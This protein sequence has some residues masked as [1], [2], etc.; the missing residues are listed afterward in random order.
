MS[1]RTTASPITTTEVFSRTFMYHIILLGEIEELQKKWIQFV[2]P[3]GTW[4]VYIPCS[5]TASMEYLLQ[6]AEMCLLVCRKQYPLTK[7]TEES[8]KC[9]VLQKRDT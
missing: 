3:I 7:E 8:T 9:R 6:R 2:S 5:S 4:I 1:V